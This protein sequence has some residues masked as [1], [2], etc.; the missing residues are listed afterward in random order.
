MSRKNDVLRGAE[1]F[2]PKPRVNSSS[3]PV[4]DK[5]TSEHDDMSSTQTEAKWSV[6]LPQ[7]AVDEIERAFFELRMRKVK[8]TRG[9]LVAL[10]IDKVITQVLKG[11]F[12]N[13]LGNGAYRPKSQR[14]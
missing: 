7:Q 6:R 5:Q 13:M 9:A 12:D 14:Q 3:R 4:A 8:T 10:C 2:K 11:K 1:V